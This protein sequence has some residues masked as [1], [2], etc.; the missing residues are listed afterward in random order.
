[1]YSKVINSKNEKLRVLYEDWVRLFSQVCAY[2]PDKL[3]GLEKDYDLRD[4]DDVALLFAIHTYY[5]LFMKLLAAEITYLFGTGKWLKPYVSEIEDAHMKGLEALKRTLEDLESGGIFRKI[6]GITNFVEGDY[7]SWY[8]EE[9]D[10]EVANIVS[11]IAK[12]LSDYEPATPILEPEY[13]K[14]LLKR[15][16]QHLV[17]RKVR[18][19]LGEFYTP[20]W[21]AELVLDEAGFTFDN[22][23]RIGR[24]KDDPTAPLQLK[25]LD[26]R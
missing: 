16:Y 15:L 6:L 8:L 24:E 25:L 11:N 4:V 23:E 12:K 5:A 10:D 9:F 26:L 18:H 17:P 20:D 21:L 7:F 3:K 14:D 22:F 1:M 2:S 13:A 19:D